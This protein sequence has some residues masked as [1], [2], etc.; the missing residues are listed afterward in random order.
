MV[1]DFS[2]LKTVMVDCIHDMYDH[3][4]IFY[5]ED[6]NIVLWRLLKDAHGMNIHFIDK[7]PT[8]ENLAEL[9]FWEMRDHILHREQ[10]D[11]TLIEVAVWETPTSVAVYKP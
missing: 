3:G 11:W 8:A 5:R 6:P 10:S 1:V 4:A 9:F 7:I 2:D